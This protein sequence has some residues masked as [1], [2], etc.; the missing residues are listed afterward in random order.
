MACKIKLP[1]LKMQ[2]QNEMDSWLKFLNHFKIAT[3]AT[4][5]RHKVNIEDEEQ[6]ASEAEKK[7][8][9]ALPNA[10]G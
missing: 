1:E 3:I 10:I 5:V 7:E 9:V 4:D 2:P 6:K 8:G